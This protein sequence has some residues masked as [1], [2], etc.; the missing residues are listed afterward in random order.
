MM[1]RGRLATALL[2]GGAVFAVGT[3]VL[4]GGRPMVHAASHADQAVGQALFQEKGC[5]HCHGPAL[6][7]TER[8][9][10]LVGVGRKLTADGLRQQIMAGGGGMPAFGDVLAPDETTHL[11]EFLAAQKKR[12]KA[13][14]AVPVPPTPKL[15]A[16][17]SDDQ[18]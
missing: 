18:T 11:V 16:N 15:P 17:G 7:G 10:A 13:G 12:V 14:R 1:W 6:L 8:G 3:L 2:L 9:P 4:P 5:E